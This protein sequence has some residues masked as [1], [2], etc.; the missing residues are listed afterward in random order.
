MQTLNEELTDAQ[1]INRVLQAAIDHYPR[2]AAFRFSLQ[3]ANADAHFLPENAV[4][5]FIKALQQMIN[6][7]IEARQPAQPTVLRALWGINTQRGIQILL[8][9]NHSTFCGRAWEGEPEAIQALIRQAWAAAKLDADFITALTVHFPPKP[10]LR[11]DRTTSGRF[12]V[13]YDAL[14]RAAGQLPLPAGICQSN[15]QPGWIR[16]FNDRY[17][18]GRFFLAAEV[19]ILSERRRRKGTGRNL[20]KRAV[21]HQ[22]YPLPTTATI[23]S[24]LPRR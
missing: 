1:R 14:R 24:A 15:A 6:R 2:L 3:G 20:E 12:A 10:C 23:A 17:L 9:L 13:E 8:L 5:Q 7:Y 19:E 22:C 21:T 16:T 11:A 18:L 4:M